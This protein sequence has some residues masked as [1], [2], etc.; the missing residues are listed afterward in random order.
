MKW[1]VLGAD[2]RA[3][4]GENREAA[5]T[6]RDHAAI[7]VCP[8]LGR[9]ERRIPARS[10]MAGS[11]RSGNAA[12]PT[13]FQGQPRRGAASFLFA[14]ALSAMV[15][16]EPAWRRST[17]RICSFRSFSN[18]ARHALLEDYKRKRQPGDA[19]I[20]Q[21]AGTSAM[22]N[23]AVHPR[24]EA[25]DSD[26]IVLESSLATVANP[27]RPLRLKALNRG[28]RKGRAEHAKKIPR[29]QR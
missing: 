27:L 20:Q 28:E 3:C 18:K 25:P 15:L 21:A 4:L 16:M 1:R 11:C 10:L 2:C 24:S 5:W 6:R 23:C 22:A 19:V 7:F 8:A 13:F 17:R 29:Q 26:P 14:T 9:R 12:E